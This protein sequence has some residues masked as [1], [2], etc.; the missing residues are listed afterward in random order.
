MSSRPSWFK[1][2]E[3]EMKSNEKELKKTMLLSLITVN[4]PV[5]KSLLEPKKTI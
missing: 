1:F 3:N 2:R 4:Y 5:L